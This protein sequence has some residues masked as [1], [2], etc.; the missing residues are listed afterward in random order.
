MPNSTENT[1]KQLPKWFPTSPGTDCPHLDVAWLGPRVP[2]RN[3]AGLDTVILVSN[4]LA[5]ANPFHDRSLCGRPLHQSARLHARGLQRV[6]IPRVRN[7]VKI[8]TGCSTTQHFTAD[9]CTS[10]VY[11]CNV[12]NLEPKRL[13]T[14]GV[15]WPAGCYPKAGRQP[16]QQD[17]KVFSNPFVPVFIF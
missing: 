4:L 15:S 11:G 13:R 3:F 10:E 5:E 7:C 2:P 17:A 9:L 16:N 6:S 1:S 12:P 14:I 8:T